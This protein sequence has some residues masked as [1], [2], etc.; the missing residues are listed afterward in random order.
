MVVAGI[1]V[2]IAVVAKEPIISLAGVILADLSGMTLTI[3]K[4]Y[5]NP[6]TETTAS[7]LLVATASLFGML[8]VGKLSYGILLYPFYLMIANYSVPF[9]Q[10]LSRSLHKSSLSNEF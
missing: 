8:T 5:I 7:W 9:T 6:N 4:T 3:K 10:F 1:G 2:V